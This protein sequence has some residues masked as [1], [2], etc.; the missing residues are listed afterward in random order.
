VRLVEHIGPEVLGITFD[1]G[2]VLARCE[3]PV[4]AARRVAPM[5]T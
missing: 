1:T 4:A 5:S 2:N 3:D